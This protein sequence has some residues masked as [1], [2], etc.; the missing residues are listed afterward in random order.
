VTDV[1]R[2]VIMTDS[3]PD[4]SPGIRT[5]DQRLRVFVSS[6]IHEL[7][8]ERAA[9]RAAIEQL[10]LAPVM[11][12][13]GANPHPAQAVYHAFIDQSDIFVGIYWERYG[14]IGPDT[15]V[16]GLEDELQTAGRMPRL[17]YVKRPAPEMEPGLDRML[18]KIKGEGGLTYKPFASAEELRELLLNDLA[19]LITERF[20]DTGQAGHRSSVPAPVTGLVGRERDVA[21]VAGLVL[22]TD[23]RLVVLTGVGGVGKTRLALAVLEET[24]E[25]WEDGIAF[26]DLSDV[27]DPALVPEAIA[28]A[29]GFTRQGREAP[30]DTL[31]RRLADRHVLIVLDN[32]DQVAEAAPLLPGL[33]ERAPRV[34][35]LVTSR[36]VLRVRGEREWRVEPLG[37]IPAEGEPDEAPAVRLFLDRIRD[38]RPGFEL[39]AD[40]AEAVAELCRRLDGLPLALELAASWMRLLNPRQLLRRFDEHMQRPGALVDLPDRQRT[41][42]ATVEWSY[43]LL[44]EGA[45]TM[46]AQLSLFAAP[47]TADAVE[48]VCEHD[49]VTAAENLAVL[50]DHNMVSPAERPDGERAFRM[51][52]VIRHF[53]SE[54][55]D[56][57]DHIMGHLEKYLLD[58]LERAGA[59][60]GSQGW[61]RRLLDSE[62]PNLLVVLG[63]AAERQ[64]PAGELLRRIGD[65]WVW[66]LVR[67]YLH[68]ASAL[69]TRIESWP[70]AG[71][72]GER[73]M[74]ARHWL[75]GFALQDEGDFARLG[76]MADKVLPEARRQ[77]EPARLGLWVMVRAVSRPYAA[78]SPAGGESSEALAIARKAG[79]R[80]FLGY[81]LSH[82]GMFLS[83][84]GDCVQ[85]RSLHEEMLAVAR[86]VGDDNLL[87]EAH[88]ALAL[89]ALLEGDP[90]PAQSHLAAAARRYADIDHREGRARCIVALAALARQRQHAALAARLIGAAEGV[91]AIGLTPWPTV[92]EAEGRFISQIKAVLPEEE[93]S[94]AVRAGRDDTAAAAFDQAWAALGDDTSTPGS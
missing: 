25:E 88:Y 18:K 45:K 50:V 53:V 13:S 63:W 90:G 60:H 75:L 67:G 8:A 36:V 80:V 71:L 68:R 76:A 40:D 21:E 34:R 56:N 3:D 73:D 47:F 52:N 86:S 5:R 19:T 62:F 46:L 2:L 84:D 32:F 30:L 23:H 11:F 1:S 16:S 78:G 41:M 28:M 26:A 24:R 89:D 15:E 4:P 91:R 17:L 39:S 59:Q 29:L 33:L 65:V 85:A 31:E 7:E 54:R 81:A 38:A 10:R 57:R 51:L 94:A 77:E 44:P 48:A 74:L 70:P 12:E 42:T 66:L 93:F 43:Q 83:I 58:V 49:A 22:A 14:W 9:A 69:S 37:L 55:L 61:A 27:S 20:G 35:L 82:R 92:A 79:D 72:R 64:R 87:A 6:T